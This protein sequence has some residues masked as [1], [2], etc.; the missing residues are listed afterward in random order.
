MTDEKS[1]KPP[2]TL[3]KTKIPL[4]RQINEHRI[5]SFSYFNKYAY[6]DSF[7]LLNWDANF[8]IRL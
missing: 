7:Q 3:N 6:E 5:I 4:Y 8:L 1:Q 2:E